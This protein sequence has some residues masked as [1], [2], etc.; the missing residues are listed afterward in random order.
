MDVS[1]RVDQQT[2]D[3][4]QSALQLELSPAEIASSVDGASQGQT[5]AST[6]AALNTLE[7][8]V[9]VA[10]KTIRGVGSRA[11]LWLITGRR[12]QVLPFTLFGL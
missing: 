12:G 5:A 8:F 7:T 11:P 2:L 6:I 9:A 10:G 3:F 1:N 4:V